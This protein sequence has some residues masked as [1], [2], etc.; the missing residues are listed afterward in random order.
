[1]FEAKLLGTPAR[2]VGGIS[3]T[4]GAARVGRGGVV[5]M[6]EPSGAPTGETRTIASGDR[7]VCD[8]VDGVLDGEL[9]VLALKWGWSSK[10]ESS[11]GDETAV[12]FSGEPEDPEL[13][14]SSSES[15]FSI[16]T[17]VLIGNSCAP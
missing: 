3:G 14:I 7:A 16:L 12:E 6:C 8:G 1:M 15:S 17:G 9:L 11:R 13:M 5:G 2:E 4:E 10:G